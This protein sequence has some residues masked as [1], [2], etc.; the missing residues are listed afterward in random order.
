[1]EAKIAKSSPHW[2]C[3]D[4]YD[5]FRLWLPLPE[6]F[7]QDCW[8]D[9]LKV[10]YNGTTKQYK[11][12]VGVETKVMDFGGIAGI[13]YLDKWWGWPISFTSY[14]S[15]LIAAYE[16]VGYKMGETLFGAPYDWR[17]P[18]SS[19]ELAETG[20]FDQFQDLIENIFTK[21]NSS[22][23]I[24]THSMGG[25]TA[26]AF[27]NRMNQTWLD[28]YI[29]SFIPIAS[30]WA[31]AAKPLRALVSGDNFGIEILGFN[32][33]NLE[34]VAQ[35]ARQAGGIVE[36][37]PATK[38]YGDDVFVVRHGKNYTAKELPQLFTDIGSPITNEVYKNTE[39]LL[40][41][42]QAPHVNTHCVY[43]YGLQ[44]EIMYKYGDQWTDP[45]ISYN[46]LGDGTVPE[47]SLR[48]CNIWKTEQPQPVEVKEFNLL[49]HSAILEDDEVFEYLISLTTK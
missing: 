26:L 23:H 36:L 42:L 33:I 25:P 46:D 16:A 34:D 29:A 6:L 10:F 9:N 13:D 21:T 32:L 19:R 43:G 22:V 20:F 49:G 28:K 45:E 48:Q 14:Y 37:V 3:Y 41:D 38:F 4:N 27:F 47:D 39:F 24:L 17:V 12:T 11:N 7:V 30:P 5:W 40:N 2:Y 15:K 44:T 31:G 8:F 35:L 1:L 18:S